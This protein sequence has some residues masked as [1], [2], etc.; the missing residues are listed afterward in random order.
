MTSNC[1]RTCALVAM[2]ASASGVE[3]PLAKDHMSD[4]IF[5]KAAWHMKVE[6]V[7]ASPD[8]TVVTTTGATFTFT[9]ANATIQC[10]QRIGKKRDVLTITLGEGALKGLGI[11][12]KDTGAVILE[13]AGGVVAKV[14]CD[15][16]LMLRS[17]AG[18]VVTCR[19]GVKE[20]ANYH[21]RSNRLWLDRFGA[22]GVY[23]IDKVGLDKDSDRRD[24]PSY[25]LAAGGEIWISIGPPRPYPW[26]ESLELRLV[27]QGSW[28][29]P[30]QAVPSD[31]KIRGYVG[32][33]SLLLLQGEPML[34]KSWKKAYEPR[35]P[36]ELRR[37]LDTSHKLGLRV[38]VYTSPFYFT[39]GTKGKYVW[40]GENLGLYLGALES[41]LGQ[42]PDTDGIY[43]DGIYGHS[44]KNTYI[45]CRATREMI[46]DDRVLLVHSTGNAPGGGGGQFSFNPAADTWANAQ[47]RGEHLGF[48]L[49]SEWLR[50]FVSCYQTSNAIGLVC[51]NAGYY[52]PT[53]REVEMTLRANCRLPYYTADTDYWLRDKPVNLRCQEPPS[54]TRVKHIKAMKEWYWPRLNDGYRAWFERA[55]AS[56]D[57]IV[58]PP[59]PPAPGPPPNPVA[60]L[61]LADVKAA[62]TARLI[63]D[64][65]GTD[66]P[67]YRSIVYLNGVEVGDL[68]GAAGNEWIGPVAIDVPRAA[69]AAVTADNALTIKNLR[70]DGFKLRNVY[71]EFTLADGRKASSKLVRAVYCSTKVWPHGYDVDIA[72]PMGKTVRID[73]PLAVAED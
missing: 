18:G 5:M 71:L 57:I 26:K 34:W 53:K 2:C 43:F 27:W 62:K 22:V 3:D 29:T 59:P 67:E 45:C 51:N 19:L 16:L 25:R 49:G 65:F 64:S 13:S 35:L 30:E 32:R 68:P 17:R 56:G 55:N 47:L 37:V 28:E 20:E 61:T 50:Y 10:A 40:L 8:K 66:G 14:N 1:F 15:S 7:T 41:Y 73:V 42:Y 36:K 54:V 24:S 33:G 11:K 6:N 46:G 48:N 70:Q 38:M 63:F 31:D 9:T 72:V 23:P 44:V 4:Q 52:V 60:G 69:L 12:A 39:K 21:V 58:P